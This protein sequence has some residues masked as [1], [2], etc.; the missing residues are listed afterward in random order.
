MNIAARL[1]TSLL[2]ISLSFS[3]IVCHENLSRWRRKLKFKFASR[4]WRWANEYFNS[5]HTPRRWR[6]WGRNLFYSGEKKKRKIYIK[7]FIARVECWWKKITRRNYEIA[8]EISRNRFNYLST[9]FNLLAY[10]TRQKVLSTEYIEI[11]E[12]TLLTDRVWAARSLLR[13][14]WREC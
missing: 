6:S 7:D 10:L 11:R 12:E 1:R 3:L 5:Y 14:V 13:N 2:E 9:R 4:G 8:I